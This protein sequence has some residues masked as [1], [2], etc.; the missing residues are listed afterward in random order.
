MHPIEIPKSLMF[1]AAPTAGLKCLGAVP[2]DGVCDLP[3]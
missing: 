3:V 1:A 2:R